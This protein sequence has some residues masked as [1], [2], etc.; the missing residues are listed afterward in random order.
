MRDLN[1]TKKANSTETLNSQFSTRKS[2]DEPQYQGNY[3][4]YTAQQTILLSNSVAE[5]AVL[6]RENS[7]L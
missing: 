7:K 4:R 2:F 3:W 5:L 6:D 1:Y